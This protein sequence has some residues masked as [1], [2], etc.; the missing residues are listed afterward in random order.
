MKTTHRKG[1]IAIGALIAA[2]AIAFVGFFGIHLQQ[3]PTSSQVFGAQGSPAVQSQPSHLSG[4]GITAT[5]NTINLTQ[6][7]LSDGLTPI[8]M[9]MF[10]QGG[11]GYATLEPGTTREEN[12]SFTGV[13]QN[14]NGT[15]QLTGVTRGLTFSFPCIST[16]TNQKAHAGGV[17]LVL[18]NSNCFYQNFLTS[19]NDASITGQ[20]EFSQAPL[21]DNAG[22]NASSVATYGQLASTSFAGTVNGSVSAKGIY[23]EATNAQIASGT[24]VGSTGADLA[25]TTRVVA[26]SS[27]PNSIVATTPSG[28]IG[29]SLIGS[30]TTY[31][32]GGLNSASTTLTGVTNIAGV[33]VTSTS[34]SKFGGT[35]ADGAFNYTTGTAVSYNLGGANIFVKNF[36]SFTLSGT[37][38]LAFTNPSANGTNIIFKVQ[39]NCTITSATTTAIEIASLGSAGGGAGSTGSATDNVFG[40]QGGGGASIVNSGT[41]GGA[42]TSGSTNGGGANTTYGLND[43]LSGSG[44]GTTATASSGI[45]VIPGGLTIYGKSIMIAPST[46]GGG[47]GGSNQ[48]NTGEPGHV[49]G[50]GAGALYM[51]CG[52]SLNF[53]SGTVIDADGIAGGNNT[54]GVGHEVSGSGG[55]GGI[56]LIVYNSLVSAF[57]TIN[58][59]GGSAGTAGSGSAGV[60]GANGASAILKNTEF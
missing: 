27:N 11:V 32:V 48:S 17:S 34:F 47:S 53:A 29:S 10:G 55:A 12:V 35:G 15:A 45:S 7:L 59:A 4:S 31:T 38:S 23:Q 50:A 49:G 44:G 54:Q 36:T 21:V 56:V 16:S 46:G 2:A 37:S 51:E 22:T 20:Y 13:V 6:F 52:G 39:G 42:G 26:T 33:N 30:G 19:Q 14:T 8:T 58:V 24:A 41:S 40:G 5:A 18:S 60:A 28:T 57:G 1:S 3:A 25:L 9:S 43:Y